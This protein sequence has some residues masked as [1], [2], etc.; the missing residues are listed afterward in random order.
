MEDLTFGVPQYSSHPGPVR[1]SFFPSPP[2]PCATVTLHHPRSSAAC[3]ARLARAGAQLLTQR[4]LEISLEAADK[5]TKSRTGAG[6]GRGGPARTCAR[7]SWV[8]P[9]E[10][11]EPHPSTP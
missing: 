1:S 10:R 2:I 6:D 11:T 9:A 5:T 8:G 7:G 3:A 4:F